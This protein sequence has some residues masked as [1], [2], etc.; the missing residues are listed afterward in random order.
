MIFLELDLP[1]MILPSPFAG[2]TLALALSFALPAL[3]TGIEPP[4][5]EVLAAQMAAFQNDPPGSIFAMQPF[6]AEETV[7]GA[8]GLQVQL[9]SMN[10]NIN[11]WFVLRV[12]EAGGRPAFY[13]LENTDPDFWQI[14]LGG[15]GDSPYMVI[16]GD[17]I[18]GECVPWLGRNS[19]LDVAADSGL[20]YAAICDERIYLRNR[21]S[22]SRSSREAIA[23]F[24]RENVIFGDSIVNLIK[25]TF[26]VDAF[27]ED[28]DEIEE[29]DAG[30]VVASLGQANLSRSP[31]MRASPGF[32]L[33]GAEGGMEAG[34]WYA[35]ENAPGI[36]SSVMQ[37]GMISEDI[38]NRR[39][40]TNWLDA[41]ERNADV[42]L[43]AFDMETFEIGYE[44]G[45]DHPAFGWSPRP[46]RSGNDWSIP[47]PD[48]FDSP[49]PLVMNGMLNPGYLDRVA[50]TFTGGYKREHGAF[51][52]GDLATYNSG[53]HY[54]FLV[55][56]TI[57]S[58][59]WPGLS[60]I[61]VMNDGTFGMVTWT[62]EME[63][64]L[65]N[66]RFA[67][68]NGVALINPDPETGEGV[69][70]ER[71]TQWGAGNWSGSAEAQLRTL[72]AGTCLREV[73]GR[74]FLIYAYF[75]TA[76]PSGMARTFQAYGCDYAMLM[77][78]NSQELTYMALY[79]QTDDEDWIEAQHLV[80]GMAVVDQ[81][82]RRG[83][84]PRFVGYA[85][86]RD[87][88]YLLRRE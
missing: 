56:G 53:H 66:M 62:E 57:L 24:L 40:E 23:D 5:A 83:R 87:F 7:E 67:R 43:V 88:F 12:Q 68:Q 61:Y 6:R 33:I 21:V 58:R 55:N 74:Q 3:A 48:G 8:D 69:P 47:G 14:A 54:G 17:D 63:A 34:S 4:S 19:E 37:P 81:N 49:A 9:I 15:D 60:T 51:R 52:Y 86:N 73:D 16:E 78:M 50:A 20:P 27:L 85:D 13:H 71:V 59:L 46:N 76:T 42:Y 70:G 80:P 84:I 39:G 72:R 29:A 75:S 41:V 31:V 25:G 45:T 22:G 1:G 44:L 77:D 32:D 26:Y 79:P 36:Y 10:P 18:T 82:T 35:I 11:S 64:L 38:L 28:S 65:P 30:A 2:T